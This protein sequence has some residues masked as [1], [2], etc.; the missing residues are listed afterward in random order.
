MASNGNKKLVVCP[1]TVQEGWDE[2]ANEKK[3]A[4]AESMKTLGYVGVKVESG[5]LITWTDYDGIK[6]QA[7][8]AEARDFVEKFD[9]CI[10][11]DDDGKLYVRDDV[12]PPSDD[13][14][15]TIRER[16][17][18]KIL[19]TP[20]DRA[21]KRAERA[22]RER[23]KGTRKVQ[24][25]VVGGEDAVQKRSVQIAVKSKTK[26]QR[27]KTKKA[28]SGANGRVAAALRK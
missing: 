2:I 15:M 14:V 25:Q 20:E 8:N 7:F 16:D 9:G 4:I 5:G 18:T 21:A 6:R 28:K 27:A 1:V 24:T 22:K 10:A 11:M 3:C 13:W 17:V 26:I 19:E 23:I 12:E